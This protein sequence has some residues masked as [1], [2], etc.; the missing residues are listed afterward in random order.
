MT[1][2]I[3]HRII[4]ALADRA[5]DIRTANGFTSDL[6]SS[7]QVGIAPL[8]GNGIAIWPGDETAEVD[9][10]GRCINTMPVTVEAISSLGSSTPSAVLEPVLGDLIEAFTGEEITLAFTTGSS[11]IEALDTITGVTSKQ[12]GLVVAVTVSS[13]TWADEDAAGTLTLRR[14]TGNFTASENLKVGEVVSAKAG[15]WSGSTAEYLACADLAKSIHYT[16]GGAQTYPEP[17]GARTGA[18]AQFEIRYE[19]KRGNPYAQ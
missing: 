7:V 1:D 4:A 17:G 6:G 12:T 3:R 19:T 18:R 15:A 11:E 8:A 2:T 10:Y 14:V 16:A 13:G 5:L 9:K